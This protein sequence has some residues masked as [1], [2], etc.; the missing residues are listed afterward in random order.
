MV[1][2][3]L[4]ADG[5]LLQ[6]GRGEG[7]DSDLHRLVGCLPIEDKQSGEDEQPDQAGGDGA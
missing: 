3:L 4:A 1:S 7:Y 2:Q 5:K 6:I